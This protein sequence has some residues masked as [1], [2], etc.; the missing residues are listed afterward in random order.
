MRS[1]H[2]AENKQTVL[3]HHP[4][5]EPDMPMAAR[6]LFSHVSHKEDTHL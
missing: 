6:L 1:I 3:V 5:L 4:F 2:C